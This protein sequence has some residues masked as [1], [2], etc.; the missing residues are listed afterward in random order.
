[1]A[2]VWSPGQ[3][4]KFAGHRLRPA[5]DLLARVDV[6]DP[7]IVYDLGC[8]PGNS[9]ILLKNRWPEASITGLDNSPDMLAQAEKDHPELL[10]AEADLADWSAPVP[11]DVLFS[12]AVLHWLDEHESRFP[13]LMQSLK[14]GGV[15]AV[16]MPGNFAAPSHTCIGEAAGPWLN[17]IEPVLRSDP[18]A[19]PSVYHQI[20]KPVSAELDIWETTYIQELEGDNAAAE[21]LKGSYL[22]PVLDALDGDE[23]EDFFDAYS[24]L[25][26]KAY[27]QR[28]DGKTL[29]PFRRVFIVARK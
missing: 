5:L 7:G 25:V 24:A 3:Y 1:M 19:S 8:G 4:L 22:K 23:K 2:H 26:Q 14:P 28:A 18:V 15:L 12:N 6:E 16:Q 21:W 9:T 17:K 10:W 20:L 29:Y 11:A 13:R 27:P